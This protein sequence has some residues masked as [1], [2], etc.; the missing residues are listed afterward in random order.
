M[1]TGNTGIEQGTLVNHGTQTHH[2][3]KGK[4]LLRFI[5]W[6]SHSSDSNLD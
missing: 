4:L 5:G 1:Q 6:W 2:R 3:L